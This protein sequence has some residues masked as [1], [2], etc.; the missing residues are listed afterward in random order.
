LIGER[1]KLDSTA[2]HKFCSCKKHFFYMFLL[3][4][5]LLSVSVN[6]RSISNHSLIN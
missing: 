6:Y 4:R 2:G 3:L 5:G 1:L